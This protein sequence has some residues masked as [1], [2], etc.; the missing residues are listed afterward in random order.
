MLVFLV[1]V[2]FHLTFLWRMGVRQSEKWKMLL[3]ALTDYVCQRCATDVS[4]GVS[5]TELPSYCVFQSRF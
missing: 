3:M 4:Y 1:I 5:V 2:C